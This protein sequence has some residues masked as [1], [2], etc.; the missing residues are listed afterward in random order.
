[1][2]PSVTSTRLRDQLSNFEALFSHVGQEAW[3]AKPN[4]AKWSAREN[5]AHLGRYHEILLHRVRRILEEDGPQFARYR[6]E[7]D[8]EWPSWSSLPVQVVQQRI[9]E[10]RS[11]LITLLGT[12]REPQLERTG[13]HPILGELSIPQWLEFFLL[14]EAHHLYAILFELR[15]QV[16]F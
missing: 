15:A 16:S 8:Q 6:A 11:E 5:L 10:L 1:M 2:L 3:E 12:L 14:H 7:L 9:R 13:S 4:P